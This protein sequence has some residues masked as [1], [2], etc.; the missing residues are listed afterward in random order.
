MGQ[1]ALLL[2]ALLRQDVRLERVLALQ[3]ARAGH[4]KAL[5]R[6]ALGL[7][8]RHVVRMCRFG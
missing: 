5:L 1:V 2:G 8:L 3:L 6:A 7:H 4:G